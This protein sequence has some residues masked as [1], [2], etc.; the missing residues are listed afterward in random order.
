MPADDYNIYQDDSQINLHN[1]KITIILKEDFYS[2]IL[3][4]IEIMRLND[5]TYVTIQVASVMN[6]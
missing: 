1:L 4:S 5:M 2:S 6:G 3:W